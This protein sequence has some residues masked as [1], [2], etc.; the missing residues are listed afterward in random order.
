[1]NTIYIFGHQNPDTDSICA[2]LSYAHLKKQIGKDEYIPVRLGP[3]NKETTYALDFFGV[4]PPRL[5]KD[6]KPQV[7]DLNLP[8]S[9][10]AYQT[11][12]IKEV[13]E[14]I[15]NKIGRS[16]PVVDR[17]KRLIGIVSISDIVPPFLELT[18]R[19]LLKDAKTPYK[20]IIR[21]LEAKVITG[22]CHQRIIKGNVYLISDL[23]QGHILNE[24][25]I[26]IAD[27]QDDFMEQYATN[28]CCI[29]FANSQDKHDLLVDYPGSV[30]ITKYSL[31]EIVRLI[32]YTVPI[33]SM[34]RKD[35]LE[36]FTT[37]E[38]IDDVMEN[39][40]T[41]GHRR[42]PVVDELGYI[43]GM[44]SR[45]NLVDINRKKA[46]LVDHNE[47]N[48][49]IK[50]IEEAEIIEV[51]DH[52]RVANV[53]TIAPLYFRLEPLGCTCT[54]IAKMYEE[55]KIPISKPMAGIMLSAII[56]DTLLFKSPTCTHEDKRIGDML[57]KI[58]EVDIQKYGM[59]LITAGSSLDKKTPDKIILGDMKK[60]MFGKYKVMISQINTGDF[61]GFYKMF[62]DIC[63]RM[64]EMCQLEQIDLAVLMITDIVVGGTEL[65]AVGKGRWM[66]ENAFK[67]GKED[68]SIFLPDVFSRKK[69]IV[70]AL[71]NAAKL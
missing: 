71:M 44:I 21:E 46:I 66:A 38:T 50:G 70:P 1:M 39:M 58:A 60:F 25:D 26:L 52:H 24:E 40:L 56:S 63:K 13:L 42:F 59:K 57:A 15:I 64:E 3:V 22:D 12:T 51:I 49:S 20:N 54:I 5:L 37:Y 14:K 19:T 36:Y 32:S 16:I 61:A 48:Q 68:T 8:R 43:K 18:S 67:M 62:H 28:G 65:L 53:Q 30:M 4:A 31:Y 41:S 35:S 23:K 6:L 33:T 55:N 45:S 47:K 11:D 2:A 17:N 34:V 10:V 69:Q 7:S 27:Y 29:I 9:V